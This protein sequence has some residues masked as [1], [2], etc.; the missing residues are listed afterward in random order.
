MK[1]F[2][3]IGSPVEHSLSPYLH[4]EIYKEIG[5]KIISTKINID[6]EELSTF[7]KNHKNNFYNV[8]IPHKE[9]IVSLLVSIDNSAKKIGAVNCVAK[10]KGYNTD[11]IGFK[12]SMV[13]NDID[14]KNKNCII[15]GA[16]GAARA[17]AYALIKSECDTITIINRSEKRKK[18]ILQWIEGFGNYSA[19]IDKGD[20][21]INCT[22]VGMWPNLENKP[23]Y[24]GTISSKQVVVDTIYNPYETAFLKHAKKAGAK[25][26][27]G[28]DMFIQ[29]GLASINIWEDNNISQRVNVNNVKKVLEEKLC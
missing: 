18:A 27:S 17:V 1:N 9:N 12:N 28:L 8:T 7:V 14:L 29:Q 20:I 10:S 23:I 11:W 19:N 13:V 2:A 24:K 16:G 22:P 15:L 5:E 3:V 6:S 26:V 21:I 4:E 25:I